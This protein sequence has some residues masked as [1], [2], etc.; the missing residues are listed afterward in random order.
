MKKVTESLENSLSS[1]KDMEDCLSSKSI[2]DP[3]SLES[4]M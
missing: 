2:D 3:Q 4:K 1:L